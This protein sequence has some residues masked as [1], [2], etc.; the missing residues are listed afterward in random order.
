MNNAPSQNDDIESLLNHFLQDIDSLVLATVNSA[1]EPEASYTPFVKHEGYYYIFVSELASHTR[2][3]K[4][5]NTASILLMK[6]NP[7]DHAHTR[8]RLSC[9]CATRSIERDE[10][11]YETVMQLMQQQFGS[12]IETLR[13]LSDFQLFQLKPEKGN[14]VAG[15]GQAFEV[16][17]QQ[18][19]KIRHRRP[20]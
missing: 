18:G 13:S 9:H 11:L 17:F 10:A 3:L 5:S 2:N 20:D 15:F 14:F 1:G 19:G 12:L 6:L 7:Q 4:H 8:K 16:D